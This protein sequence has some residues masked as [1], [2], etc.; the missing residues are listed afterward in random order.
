MRSPV[1]VI[2]RPQRDRTR[3]RGIALQSSVYAIEAEV[4]G[5]HWWFRGRRRLIADVIRELA[6]P[7][8]AAVLDVGSGT[9]T[10]LRLLRELGFS[11]VSAVDAS[12][13]AIRFCEEKGLGP[14]R[15]GDICALPCPDHAY[16]LIL[17][18]DIIEHVDDDAGA[19]AELHRVLRPGGIAILTVPAF[20][21]LWGLQDRVS[22]HKRRYRRRELEGRVTE[23]GLSLRSCFY[24]NYL[25]FLPIWL[26]RQC[27]DLLGIE[28]ESENE[29][30]TPLVNRI[31]GW[32]FA[33]DVS[34]APRIRPFFG[35]SLLALAQRD[36]QA[37]SNL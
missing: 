15:K 16:D 18:T 10:N 7:T 21:S 11:N 12:D 9:G 2:R 32:V 30:N 34:T 26:A 31:L 29:I 17:A 27:I 6:V 28:L 13:D 14:V 8:T 36:P 25:L 37:E 23:A 22:L 5:S 24:F 3:R 4:E 20:P 19:L 33:L 1:S 35:V